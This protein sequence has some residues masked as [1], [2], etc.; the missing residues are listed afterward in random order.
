MATKAPVV[1][2]KASVVD[3]K[4]PVVATKTPVVATKASVVPT[5][6]PVVATIGVFVFARVGSH[7]ASDAVDPPWHAGNAVGSGVRLY[8]DDRWLGNGDRAGDGLG[9]A[10]PEARSPAPSVG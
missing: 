5:K 3:T 8:H 1:D 10:V 6:T 4:T 2:T 9:H 7:S